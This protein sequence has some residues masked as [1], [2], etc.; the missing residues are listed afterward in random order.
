MQEDKVYF[1]DMS[2]MS[3]S[4]ENSE[5]EI[6]QSFAG[7]NILL[8]GGSGFLGILL[9]EKLLRCCPD[10][11]KIYL[12]LREKKNKS[13]K[14]RFAEYFD[15][16]IF[17]RLKKGQSDFTTKIIMIEADVSKI[18]LGLSQENRKQLLDTHVI[19]HGAATVRFN[20]SLRI[21]VNIN[22][23]GTKQLLLLAKEMPNF[24][25]FVHIS[26]AF[27]HCIYKFIDEKY[28]KPPMETDKLLALVDILEDKKLNEISS[29]LIGDW[30]NTYTYT[31][32]VAEDTVRQYGTGIPICIIRPA[33]V[34]STSTEPISGW[35][36][37]LYGAIGIVMGSAMGLL[38]TM[39]CNPEYSAQ[40][41]PVDYVISHIIVAAWDTAKRKDILLT[42]KDVNPDVS[43][44]KGTPIYN[45]VSSER[46]NIS[47]KT[48]MR[49]NE[50][51]G[52]EVPSIQIMWCYMLFL[53]KHLFMHKLCVILMHIIPGAIGDAVLFLS[54]RKPMLLKTYRKI[55][56]FS[57]VISYFSSQ[58]WNFCDDAVVKLWE[59]VNPADRQIFNFNI[60]NLNWKTYISHMIPGIRVY[61]IKDPLCTVQEG[62]R[63]YRRLKIAHYTILTIIAI[64][65][66]WG[67]IWLGSFLLNVIY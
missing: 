5:P 11:A 15:S 46:N 57:F 55:N 33:I 21:A 52:M 2:D 64:L 53:N 63:R 49:Y 43:E 36:N 37:N 51:Y 31:K 35:T 62:R 9:V 44:T 32:A 58:Q 29:I 48:F 13:P 14:E 26:T 8:T 65:F 34:T 54:G 10:I 61:M 47:W 60:M 42:I 22:V 17:D 24:K 39:H 1:N 41:V 67:L 23:R 30:P 6:P 12:L 19:F 59:R 27:C 16:P 56:T 38:H 3:N 66:I 45:Y 25:V 7:C 28:Y 4:P 40:I 18:D 20:E 50:L